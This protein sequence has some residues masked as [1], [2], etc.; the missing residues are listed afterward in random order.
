MATAGGQQQQG[1]GNGSA[2]VFDKKRLY[3]KELE[4]NTVFRTWAERFVSWITMDNEEV[5]K[6]FELAA[7][8]E[9]TLDLSGLNALQISYSKAVYGHLASLTE[10]YKKAARIIRLVKQQNGLEAWR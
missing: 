9:K 5:G 1:T 7:R 2:G 4:E 3:P 8:Q 6:A 10:N